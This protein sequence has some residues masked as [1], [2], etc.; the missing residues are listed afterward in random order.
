MGL[1]GCRTSAE[2]SSRP[3][4]DVVL[5][6]VA[7]VLRAD[8]RAAE[9]VARYEGEVFALVL[10]DTSAHG[11]FV[12]AERLR[13]RL[14]E[15]LSARPPEVAAST[16]QEPATFS[17]GIA[18]GPTDGTTAEVVVAK[19]QARLVEARRQGGSR[20]LGPTSPPRAVSAPTHP[21]EAADPP[22]REGPEDRPMHGP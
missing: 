2:A 18:I 10:P 15:W 4:G 16:P 9:L 22:G 13:R 17:L 6:G 21:G 12:A 19:A 5:Q 1:D 7:E 3:A 14:A 8:R 20:L 11:A